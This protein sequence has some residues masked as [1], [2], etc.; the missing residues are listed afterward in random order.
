MSEAE[1][2]LAQYFRTES[3]QLVASLTRQLGNFDLAEEA[4]QDAILEALRHWPQDGIPKQPGAWLRVTAR[5]RATDRLRRET[6]Q[7]D[8]MEVLGRLVRA[9]AEPGAPLV[10]D[11]LVLLFM[12]CHPTL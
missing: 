3:G 8:Q 12:C 11:R 5:R 4:V 2:A 9:E 10:D 1:D 7:R 6:R